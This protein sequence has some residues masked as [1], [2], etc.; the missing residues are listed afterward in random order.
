MSVLRNKICSRSLFLLIIALLY[1]SVFSGCASSVRY[2]N[3][4]FELVEKKKEVL[5]A[6]IAENDFTDSLMFERIETVEVLDYCVN[7]CCGGYGVSASSHEFGFY[8]SFDDQPLGVWDDTEFCLSEGLSE[9]GNGFSG[10]FQHNSY[11]TEKICD[12]FWYYELHF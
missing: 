4:I 5:L 11:Y 10:D 6:D 12:Y 9:T 1:I 2:K 7:F 3:E 8:Y